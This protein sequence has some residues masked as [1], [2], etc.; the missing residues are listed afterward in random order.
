MNIC[1]HCE[2]LSL[3]V[4]E[5]V[6]KCYKC[7]YEVHTAYPISFEDEISRL[8]ELARQNKWTSERSDKY[9]NSAIARREK[10][11]ET[12]RKWVK[13]NKKYLSEYRK[14]RRARMK[15]ER[16]AKNMTMSIFIE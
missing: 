10:E 16:E 6:F 8:K 2:Q 15:Q 4:D 3:E 5:P 11:R 9:S 1:P 13:K 14:A 7:G 12:K